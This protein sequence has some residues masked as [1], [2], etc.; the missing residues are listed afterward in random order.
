MTFEHAEHCKW[1]SKRVP[2]LREYASKVN[3]IL[4]DSASR[5]FDTPP[6]DVSDKLLR[7]GEAAKFA[8]TDTNGKLYA[9]QSEIM[10]Q[11]EEFEAKLVLEYSKLEM[12]LYIQDLLNALELEQAEM[13]ENYRHD[14][15]YMDKLAADVDARRCAIIRGK[16][17]IESQLIDYKMREAEAER[18]GLNK[19][20]ELIAAQ[21]ETARERL[22]LIKWLD[23][24]II[25]EKAIII[26]EKQRADILKLIIN[27]KKEIV[28]IK[29]GMIPLYEDKADA[30]IL[31]AKT[32][33]DEIVWKKL[34]IE[35]GFRKIDVKDA[36]ASARVSINDKETALEISQL[37][38]A[39][40]QNALTKLKG[41]HDASLTE[42][43]NLIAGQILSIEESV[44]KSA[45]NLR[46]D[47]AN[48]RLATSIANDIILTNTKI[49][50]LQKV[51]TSNID[52]ILGI[53]R[54]ARYTTTIAYSHSKTKT[55]RYAQI[56]QAI[57]SG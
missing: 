27:I 17:D 36:E 6:A 32:I 25:K 26:F 7:L 11:V 39:V 23:E 49:A 2:V 14:K 57:S 22:K 46:L 12:A 50:N 5:G 15:A 56:A 9:E 35:L 19:E 20:L 18:I 31:Q 45:I 48:I 3:D 40:A 16:A 43:S 33:T 37:A 4:T 52:K 10:F 28:A 47:T 13:K 54:A 34:L 41:E 38:L 53:A 42:Y 44:K 51:V 21:I 29:E 1:V 24:L 8:L 55:T 30:K